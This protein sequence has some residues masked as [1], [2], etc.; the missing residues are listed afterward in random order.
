MKVDKKSLPPLG[1]LDGDAL[2]EGDSYALGAYNMMISLRSDT[3]ISESEFA[4][5]EDLRQQVIEN[6]DEIWKR[7]QQGREAL[8]VFIKDFAYSM[9]R[10]FWYVVVT[11]DSGDDSYLLLF[12]FPTN[13]S[14]L[15]SRYQVGDNLKVEESNKVLKH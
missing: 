13:D 1:A 12:S 14:S 10:R 5:Y 15:V 8:L 6:P 9:D 2:L 7:D 3:D 4:N 11:Q